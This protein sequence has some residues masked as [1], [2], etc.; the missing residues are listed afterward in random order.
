ML[1]MW[2]SRMEEHEAG[3]RRHYPAQLCIHHLPGCP[4]QLRSGVSS[5]CLQGSQLSHMSK[6]LQIPFGE[7]LCG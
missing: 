5:M 6:M 4:H 7:K 2:T 3:V 1:T